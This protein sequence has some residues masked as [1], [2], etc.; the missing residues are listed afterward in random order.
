MNQ[1]NDQRQRCSEQRRHESQ[2]VS[3]W[4]GSAAQLRC[5]PRWRDTAITTIKAS[6]STMAVTTMPT[7]TAVPAM[8]TAESSPR[9]SRTSPRRAGER[10]D[11][12]DPERLRITSPPHGARARSNTERTQDE[13]A[14]MSAADATLKSGRY[15]LPA[16]ARGVLV[17]ADPPET[18][19]RIEAPVDEAAP[20]TAEPVLASQC[21]CNPQG[22]RDFAALSR[23][24]E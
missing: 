21:E 10:G 4:W 13:G 22:G 17:L 8:A 19:W 5:L 3:P 20:S 16:H 12:R 23:V 14:R 9:S 2:L 1:T 7:T 15:E 24:A 6:R 11:A 18:G